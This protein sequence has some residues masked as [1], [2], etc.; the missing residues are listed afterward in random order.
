[1]QNTIHRAHRQSKSRF[2]CIC[3]AREK[4]K[5]ETKA[6]SYQ[7]VLLVQ[8]LS[9]DHS[10]NEFHDGSIAM[11]V[12]LRFNPINFLHTRADDD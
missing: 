10:I 6:A 1:M 11:R 8:V 7:L 4:K 9:R 12:M 2:A 5:K 3:L